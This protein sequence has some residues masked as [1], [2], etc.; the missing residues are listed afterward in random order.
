MRYIPHSAIRKIVCRVYKFII[1]MCK[2]ERYAMLTNIFVYCKYERKPCVSI[3][4][5]Y[6]KWGQAKI[7]LSL[8]CS[9]KD[10]I[11]MSADSSNH[12]YIYS[13]SWTAIKACII[14]SIAFIRHN[15]NNWWL[16][17][18]VTRLDC[19]ESMNPHIRM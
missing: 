7:M 9:R 12:K 16:K 14:S 15:Y 3:T 4:F 10:L 11:K 2:V 19:V 6:L 18:D 8:T 5:H 17:A 13:L 1:G